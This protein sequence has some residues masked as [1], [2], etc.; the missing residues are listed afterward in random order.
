MSQKYDE[1]ILDDTF[2]NGVVIK[3]HGDLHE[4][5]A[6][7]GGLIKSATRLQKKLITM[8]RKEADKQKAKA[9]KES[10]RLR[11]LAKKKGRK[12]KR[13]RST[14][15]PLEQINMPFGDDA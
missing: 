15:K 9:A 12:S 14:S 11:D 7:L 6:A 1:L 10:K 8:A 4:K 3:L 13:S 2:D 5:I